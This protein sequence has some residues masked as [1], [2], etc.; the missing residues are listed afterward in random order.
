MHC[1][2]LTSALQILYFRALQWFLE[3][4]AVLHWLCCKVLNNIILERNN[5]ALSSGEPKPLIS[6]IGNYW[7]RVTT[8]YIHC[9]I[10]NFVAW[11]ATLSD[12]A[13]Q[14]TLAFVSETKLL[15]YNVQCTSPPTSRFPLG[16]AHETCL[17][18]WKISWNMNGFYIKII[19]GPLECKTQ[20]IL[21]TVNIYVL[22]IK[23]GSGK[24]T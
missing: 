8:W 20:K 16:F 9:K 3:R 2:Y 23:H 1:S 14:A 7:L 4:S 21:L 22:Y 17:G 11:Q 18:P 13:C 15:V 12:I 5:G 24:V 19:L 6:N 10:A